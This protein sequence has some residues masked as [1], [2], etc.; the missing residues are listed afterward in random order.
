MLSV[1]LSNFYA[2]DIKKLIDEVN[3]FKDERNIWLT[4]GSVKNS[5]G[6]LPPT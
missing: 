3:A 2:R 4:T 6:N 1:I 5:V